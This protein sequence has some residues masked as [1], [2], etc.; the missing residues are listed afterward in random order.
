V[1]GQG[2]GARY[3]SCRRLGEERDV[4]EL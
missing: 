3:A 4:A 2:L 1:G